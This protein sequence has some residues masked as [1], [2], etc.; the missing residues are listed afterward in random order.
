MSEYKTEK[1]RMLAEKSWWL[2]R[3][4]ESI[5]HQ[6]RMGQL[7]SEELKEYAGEINKLDQQIHQL[8]TRNGMSHKHCTCGHQVEEQDTYCERCGQ[9]L[10]IL[11]VDYED[12]A[13]S[14]CNSKLQVGAN[15]C[16]VCGMRNEGELA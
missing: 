7:Y 12:Q 2:A 16:H 3:L 10:D 8:K 15:F 14:H 6:F 5:Y 13:C 1:E 4:G 11:N 9:K